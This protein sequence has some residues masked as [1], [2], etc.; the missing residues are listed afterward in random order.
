MARVGRLSLP[1][2]GWSGK[3]VIVS[4]ELEWEYF[5]ASQRLERDCHYL[6]EAGMGRVFL[7]AEAIV[8]RLSLPA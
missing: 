5:C 3:T 2:R 1:T 8:R 6:S 4:P 7:P